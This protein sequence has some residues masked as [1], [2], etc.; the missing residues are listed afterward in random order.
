LD[1]IVSLCVDLRQ[2]VADGLLS[3]ILDELSA[4]QDLE[5]E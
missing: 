2:A 1:Q 5:S 4:L 3:D